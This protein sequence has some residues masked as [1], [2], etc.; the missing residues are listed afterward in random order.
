[1]DENN[2][3][4]IYEEGGPFDQKNPRSLINIMPREARVMLDHVPVEWLMMNERDLHDIVKPSTLLNAVRTAF[5]LEYDLAQSSHTKMTLKGVMV[6][7][8][9]QSPT[10]LIRNAFATARSLAWI[11]H[12]PI[13]YSTLIDETLNHG[14][15]RI[16]EILSLPLHDNDGKVDPRVAELILKATAFLDVRKHGMP[17]QRTENLTKNLNVTVTK[18]DLKKFGVTKAEELDHKIQELE[19][20]L[21]T[22]A[23]LMPVEHV[24]DGNG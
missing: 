16:E 4:D 21:K 15:R 7:M 1:M 9:N 18:S 3:I 22:E 12:P 2:A 10:I 6:H 11:L 5:W 19:H 8:N 24:A 17:T 13:H 14:M 23:H 20:K